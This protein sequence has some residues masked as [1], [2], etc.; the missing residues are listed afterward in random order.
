MAEGR[1]QIGEVAERTGLSV[2]T[3]RF[4]EESGLVAPSTRSP[5]GFRLYSDDDVARLE[6]IRRLKPLDFSIEE[7]REVLLLL[8]ELVERMHPAREPRPEL[9]ERLAMYRELADQR[10][11]ALHARWSNAAEFAAH[12]R[13]QEERLRSPRRIRS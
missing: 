7:M 1:M 9:L 13:G 8:D 5:G 10:V 12:L 4:Y 3:I 11:A 6:L 2:R